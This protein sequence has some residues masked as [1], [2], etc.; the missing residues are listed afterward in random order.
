MRKSKFLFW[1]I[2]TMLVTLFGSSV[3]AHEIRPAYLEI[4][5]QSAD[6]Y[7]VLWKIPL[8]GNKAP[9]I[10]PIFPEQFSLKQIDDEFLPD[11]YIRRY[12]GS[13]QGDLNGQKIAI[14]GLDMTLVDV[15]VQ[16]NLLDESSYTFL[17]QP[18]N[19]TV[20]I[21]KEPSKWE[22]VKLYILLGV[23]HILIGIDHLLFVL[24]LL[25]LVKGLRPLIQTITA[26]TLAHSL[27]LG[28][29]TFELFRVPGPPVEEVIALSIVF[30]AREYLMVQKGE[31]S[32]T[33]Q[34]P[35]VVA[36]SFGLLHGFGF[37]GALSDI[38]FPQKEVPLALLTF[39]IGVELGQLIFI[40]LVFFLWW[41]IQKVK[42]PLP[43][44]SW[45]I[46]P[47]GMGTVAAFWLVERVVAFW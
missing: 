36:F 15:L 23:E 14:Q 45:K 13:Y 21:P 10:D 33:A 3:Y 6:G 17:L 42:L 39:N 32:M 41:I 26:F 8:L 46:M 34:Y 9:K 30:L 37:A 24:G 12:E 25:L 11:A 29:A 1:F 22:V 43:K 5:Q 4:K 7:E 44:W 40:G 19:A 35:W 31:K 18:D 20:V 28:V 38:G 47:Y 2:P 16:I 27:T